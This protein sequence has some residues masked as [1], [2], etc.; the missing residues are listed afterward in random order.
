MRTDTPREPEHH[1][2]FMTTNKFL[3]PT[4]RESDARIRNHKEE[5]PWPSVTFRMIPTPALPRLVYETKLRGP[6][7][8]VRAPAS[9]LPA[10][11]LREN[12][13]RALRSFCS[14][15]PARRRWPPSR[16]SKPRPRLLIRN[17]REIARN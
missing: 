15:R 1:S 6:T 7:G 16:P 11:L 5:N 12:L 17:G 4:F 10:Q 9:R 13:R 8:P 3:R 2:G 14:G